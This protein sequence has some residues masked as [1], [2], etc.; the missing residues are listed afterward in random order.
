M[1]IPLIVASRPSQNAQFPRVIL[2]AGRWTF[3]SNHSDSALRV[4]TPDSSVELHEG[5]VLAN[6]TAVYVSCTAS[7][8]EPS[9]TVYACLSD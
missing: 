6:P 8:N 9:I 1:R 5:L 7:G 3:S 4:N 2:R